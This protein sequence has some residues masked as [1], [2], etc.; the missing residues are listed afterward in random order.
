MVDLMKGYFEQFGDK[1][2]CYEDLIPYTNLEGEDLERWTSYLEA[3]AYSS[4]CCPLTLVL[5]Y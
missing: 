1:N 2:V 4:V 5:S 3:L